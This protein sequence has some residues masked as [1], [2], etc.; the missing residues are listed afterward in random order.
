MEREFKLLQ[1]GRADNSRVRQAD[2][3]LCANSP[4]GL[5]AGS[6]ANRGDQECPPNGFTKSFAHAP[7]RGLYRGSN[8]SI[9]GLRL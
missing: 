2:Q 8:Y 1:N 9:H 4:F 6:Q 3:G 7:S 5:A